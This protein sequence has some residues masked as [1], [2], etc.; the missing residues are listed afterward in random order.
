[1][2]RSKVE[3]GANLYNISVFAWILQ[4]EIISAL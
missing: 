3:K 2:D 1:M 4:I